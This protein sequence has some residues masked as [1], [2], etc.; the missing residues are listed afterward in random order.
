M[1]EDPAVLSSP[2]FPWAG[3]EEGS[4]QMC[5]IEISIFSNSCFLPYSSE[6]KFSSVSRMA[7]LLRSVRLKG[8]ALLRR[9]LGTF[10]QDSIYQTKRAKFPSLLVL[11][12]R[13]GWGVDQAKWKVN[14]L[15][16]FSKSRKF[17]KL[18][19]FIIKLNNFLPMKLKKK[20]SL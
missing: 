10:I 13:Q 19:V 16:L 14:L 2:A 20:Q 7:L 6:L 9:F 3:S 17:L 8:A 18:V 12:C 4:G 11:F 5:Q 15:I 1:K